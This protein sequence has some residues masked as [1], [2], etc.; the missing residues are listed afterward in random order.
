M[1]ADFEAKRGEKSF[2]YISQVRLPG[3]VGTLEVPENSKET[4][5]MM[6]YACTAM[7][8]LVEGAV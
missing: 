6:G 2:F 5:P 8:M 1:Y 7:M 4:P 3:D